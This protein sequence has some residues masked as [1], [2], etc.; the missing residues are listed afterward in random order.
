MSVTLHQSDYR[1]AANTATCRIKQRAKTRELFWA[2]RVYNDAPI[3]EVS[4][5]AS[6][7]SIKQQ[8]PSERL[9]KHIGATGI[10]EPQCLVDVVKRNMLFRYVLVLPC[11]VANEVGVF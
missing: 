5:N 8:H 4:I 6:N 3:E 2:S 9:S 10:D 7:V 11:Q 1:D